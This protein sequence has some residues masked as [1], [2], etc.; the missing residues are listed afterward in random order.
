[1]YVYMNNY[2]SKQDFG[3]PYKHLLINT[4]SFF[5]YA[6]T[7]FE[8]YMNILLTRVNIFLKLHEH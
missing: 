1:M 4:H 7:F 2:F 8:N 6:S 3:K 5:K